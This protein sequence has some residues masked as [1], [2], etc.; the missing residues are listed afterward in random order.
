[1]LSC[2]VPCEL[3]WCGIAL[4]I[5]VEWTDIELAALRAVKT[6]R[7]TVRIGTIR[8]AMNARAANG[9]VLR[10]D[11][12][13]DTISLIQACAHVAELFVHLLGNVLTISSEKHGDFHLQ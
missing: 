5:F 6:I 10:R 8:I 13:E 3:L 4:H 7:A 1:M 2:F 9:I 11:D 12:R